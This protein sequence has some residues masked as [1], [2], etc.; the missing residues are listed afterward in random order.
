V[1][2]LWNAL[3]ELSHD[4]AYER[5][6]AHHAA[7]HADTTPLTPREF[8]IREQQRKWAGVARCC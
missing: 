5:Y 2:R 3:R 8:Y 6:L 1:R 4:D 7:E